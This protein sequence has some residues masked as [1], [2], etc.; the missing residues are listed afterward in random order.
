MQGTD[1]LDLL[2]S[3]S[4]N[5]PIKTSF[6]RDTKDSIKVPTKQGKNKRFYVVGVFRILS[7]VYDGAFLRKVVSVLQTLLIST[8]PSFIDEEAGTRCFL[9][10]KVPRKILLQS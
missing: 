6:K 7:N 1:F 5:L 10:K 4:I 2:A 9:S 8:K 3:A